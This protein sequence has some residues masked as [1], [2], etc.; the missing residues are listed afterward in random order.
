MGERTDRRSQLRDK[1]RSALVEATLDCVAEL[2]IAGTSVSEITARAGLSRGMVH[3]H[4][5]TKEKLLEAA[6][7]RASEIYYGQLHALLRQAGPTPQETIDAVVRS[8]LS[9]QVLNERLVRILYAFRGEARER[10]V[11]RQLSDTRDERLRSLVYDAFLPML[12]DEGSAQASLLAHDA[13]YGLIAMLEGMW[14]DFLLHPDAFDRDEAC[15][16]VFRYLAALLP[17]HF[18]AAGAAHGMPAR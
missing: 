6:I 1:N 13:T 16:I 9:E 7:M 11:I 4:F 15:R 8:D 18:T 17:W 10:E 14:N 12:R 3:L 2:G 5:E